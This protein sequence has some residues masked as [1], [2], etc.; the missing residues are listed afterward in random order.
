MWFQQF[1]TFTRRQQPF[2]SSWCEHFQSTVGKVRFRGF[3]PQIAGKMYL[4]LMISLSFLLCPLLLFPFPQLPFSILVL[5]R[6]PPAHHPP[7]SSSSSPVHSHNSPPPPPSAIRSLRLY[8]EGLQCASSL[9]LQTSSRRH[10]H[11]KLLSL[12][13]L[14]PPADQAFISG[15]S[16]DVSI[17]PL[18][19]RWWVHFGAC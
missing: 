13:S 18:D 10:N 19:F 17:V 3:I 6:L 4:F 16:C 15:W 11:L 12:F 2:T 7:P 14:F 1:A 5:P 8:S 9:E